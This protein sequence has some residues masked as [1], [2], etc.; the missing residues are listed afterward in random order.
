MKRLSFLLSLALLLGMSSCRKT[1][2]VEAIFELDLEECQIQEAVGVRNLSVAKETSIG[3]CKWEWE[4]QFS[5]ETHP[6]TLTFTKV[7]NQTVK[8][9]VWA[10]E[11]AAPASTCTRTIRV[12]NN[13]EPPEVSFDAP[14]TAVQDESVTFTDR[15]TDRTGR[16]V[17]WLWNIGGIISAEQ[18]PTVTFISWGTGIDVTLT[19]T[20]N[21]GASSTLTKKMDV[22]RSSGHD[23]S[24]SWSKPYDT[25]GYVYWTSP[26]IS[27]D[28][29]KI[30]VSSTGYHLV[31]FDPSGNQLG[32]FDIGARGANPYSYAS[33]GT[34][35]INNQS[36]T[37]TVGADGKV[38]IPVQFYENPSSA[39]AG[40]TG[41]G[42]LYCIHPGCTGEAWYFPTGE[43][44]FYR[45]LAAPVFGD[46]VAIALKE[47]D[48]IYINQNFGIINRQNGSLVQALTCDQGSWGGVS[49]AAD[50]T[51]IYGASR[52]A[53]GY[54]VARY[55]GTWSTSANS[56]AGRLT[57]F[58]NGSDYETKGFQI[59]IST[60]NK[61]H[62]CVSSGSST[63][64][65]C[66]CYDLAAYTG[67]APKALWT[68]TVEATSYQSGFG[69]VLDAAG[70]AY[71]MAGNKVFRINGHD[72][73]KAWEYALTGG[74]IGV[75]A[76]D[77]KGYLYVC[78]V[79]GNKLL[80]LSSAS[81]QLVASVDLATPKSCPT[82]AAD[83]SIYVTG[84]SGGKPTLYKVV[85]TGAH[86]TVAPGPNWSQLGCN[87]QKNGCAPLQ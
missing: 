7:G 1:P 43:K 16:I 59:A 15:S 14:A 39:P 58:L 64:M 57:N 4:D 9:T 10:E 8:L 48:N 23:L 72:G 28:G 47:N 45:F 66:A 5:Y 20:D 76:I 63:Q 50:Q 65:V 55:N 81:G 25:K 29:S 42:G 73:S 44:S 80:K 18:N 2:S 37:P 52:K 40:T 24:L 84:N 32:S 19:V 33:G 75:A 41:N 13:N 70:N 27:P 49:V 71:Y 6:G 85:G 74:C 60:D 22:T 82:I 17:S 11:G 78:D 26:A 35:S 46:Y 34:A 30:Y 86:K 61:V 54:K 51:L 83:G 36:P 67:G 77:S 87:P 12:F 3:L 69:A 53:A 56:D 31:C 62:V 38:Y 68:T 79:N 21:Y